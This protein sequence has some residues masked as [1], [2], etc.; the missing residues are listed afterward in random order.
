[1]CVGARS[2][3]W[4]NA[5]GLY[6]RGWS[7]GEPSERRPELLQDRLGRREGHTADVNAMQAGDKPPRLPKPCKS[8]QILYY[9]IILY[10]DYFV[11]VVVSECYDE[12]LLSVENESVSSCQKV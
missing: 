6:L 11:S 8:M 2:I 9:D 10:S 7:I 12:T 5:L 1:M 3:V 4:T